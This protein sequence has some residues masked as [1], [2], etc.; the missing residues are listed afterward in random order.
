M[1]KMLKDNSESDE[2]SGTMMKKSIASL[3]KVEEE[4]PV[5]KVGPMSNVSL[6]DQHSQLKLEAQGK[7]FLKC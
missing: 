4:E 2:E 1:S 5:H 3:G 6:L 7:L